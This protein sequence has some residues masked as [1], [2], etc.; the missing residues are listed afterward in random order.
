M[1]TALY[2]LPY[3]RPT[4]LS[5]LSSKQ[6]DSLVVAALLNVLRLVNQGNFLQA[7]LLWHPF[8]RQLSDIENKDDWIRSFP[9]VMFFPLCTPGLLA[10]L[11]E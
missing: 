8:C 3:P 4:I 5:E 9:D 11:L 7:K 10:N 2:L 6:T 1:L